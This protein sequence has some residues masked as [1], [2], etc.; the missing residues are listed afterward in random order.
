MVNSPL[1]RPAIYWGGSFG[2]TLDSHD[3][4]SPPRLHLETLLHFV[5]R[6]PRDPGSEDDGSG[7]RENHI[8]NAFCI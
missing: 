3:F 2:G 7:C 4:W 8:Q 1:I 5:L 6:F